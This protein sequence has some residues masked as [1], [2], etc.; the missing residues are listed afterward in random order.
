MARDHLMG[1]APAA[2][3]AADVAEQ[4]EWYEPNEWG[5]SDPW[6]LG[7]PSS[8]R[9]EQEARRKACIRECAKTSKFENG[10]H[11]PSDDVLHRSAQ[12]AAKE[13]AYIRAQAIA[14]GD[15]AHIKRAYLLAAP[16]VTPEPDPVEEV[17]MR[18]PSYVAALLQP[19]H[20]MTEQNARWEALQRASERRQEI[21][22]ILADRAGEM[23]KEFPSLPV[24]H[25]LRYGASQPS[26]EQISALA[27]LMNHVVS[28]GVT[29][30]GLCH[31]GYIV[32]A[33]AED[34]GDRVPF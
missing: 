17:S 8:R 33:P 5:I 29:V 20:V 21:A 28:D 1:Y 13:S 2:V 32:T 12:A 10:D 3:P 15:V 34:D 27:D 24:G 4:G 31:S 6:P 7:Y 9:D 11:M 25:P 16:K 23:L 14:R 30:G 19:S 26:Q 22:R 18:V